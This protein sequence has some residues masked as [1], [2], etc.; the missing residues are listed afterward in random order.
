MLNNLDFK[1]FFLKLYL[2]PN[3]AT[4]LKIGDHI[5]ETVLSK[6]KFCFLFKAQL[7]S[8]THVNCMLKYL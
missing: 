6:L 1:D 3:K 4:H 2:R 5:S 7:G 8:K